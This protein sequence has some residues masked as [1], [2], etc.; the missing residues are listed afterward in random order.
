MVAARKNIVIVKKVTRR[1]KPP[2]G[3]RLWRSY[4]KSITAVAVGFVAIGTSITI[5]PKVLGTTE[6]WWLATH[7]HVEERIETNVAPIKQQSD[8]EVYHRL[9]D[10]KTK[11]KDDEGGWGVQL[12]K[13]TD[14]EARRRIQRLIDDA[15]G[16]QN[17]YETRMNA[18]RVP[19]WAKE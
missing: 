10:L 19:E 13:E 15:R 7:G 1:G 4:W 18:L 2:T 14:P 6:P 16:R 3:I 9:E 17:R 11:A 12:S 8:I 5:L